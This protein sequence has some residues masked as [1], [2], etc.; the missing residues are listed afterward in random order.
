MTG[1]VLNRVVA[2]PP[3]PGHRISFLRLGSRRT[4]ELT[5]LYEQSGRV[6]AY[7]RSL[8]VEPGDRIGILAANSLEWVLLDLAALR[9]KAVVAGFE[10]GKF[11]DAAELVARYGLKLLFTD[12]DVPADAPPPVRA[13]ADVAV[14]AEQ[15]WTDLP[16][17]VVYEPGEVTTIKFTS[18]STGVP[19]GLG[20]TVGS[21]DASMQAVQEIFEHRGGDNLFVFLPLSLLQQRYWIYSALCFGHDATVTTYEA[22]FAALATARPT[23]VMGVPAFFE[24]ARRQIAQD[25]A[26]M[27]GV[28]PEEARRAAARRLFG[29][30]IRYLWTGSAPADREVL[31]YLTGAGLP[32]YEGYGLNE[33]CIVSK[34][35]PGAH[36]EGSVGRVLPGKQ[37]LF[38]DDGVILVRSEHPVNRRYEFAE[39]GD[40][41]RMFVADGVVRTGDL[42][43]LD[44]DGFLFVQGRADDVIVLGNGKKVIVRPIEEHL[45]ASP[46]IEECVVFCPAQT[47]LVA[48]VSPASGTADH[49]AI[50]EQLARTNA[51]FGRDEQIR[52]VVVAS[53]RFSIANGML[54]S[55][56]KPKRQTIFAAFEAEITNNQD[57]IHAQ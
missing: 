2:G 49:A 56:F 43:Y 25:A 18:G 14:A 48:V 22:A 17:P 37:V 33:T 28:P 44:E 27:D 10:P 53:P 1:S 26:R 31:R 50:A 21:I 20:A 46:A 57:G 34:N 19:K 35:H 7:L 9:L 24:T 3:S 16:E 15:A 6:A 39:P 47:S 13:C 51:A 41:E 38:D 5:E 45:R 42:G 55:Q 23:V 32:I 4:L 54:T 12:R 30:R 29:D 11:A 36:K 52:R 40:S 8:G